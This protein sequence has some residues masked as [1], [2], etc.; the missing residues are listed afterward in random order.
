MTLVYFSLFSILYAIRLLLD[1]PVVRSLSGVSD[2][3]RQHIDLWITVILLI[4]FLLFLRQ[5]LGPQIKTLVRVFLIAQ[6][7]A[8]LAITADAFGVAGKLRYS[9]NNYLVL[10]I[11]GGLMANFLVLR[12]RGLGQPWTLELRVLITGLLVF[13]AFVLHGNLRSLGVLRGPDVE[14]F[15]FLFFVG[16][17]GYV[18]AH[19]AFAT[20]Q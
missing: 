13:G 10:A 17:L 18:A 8:A 20:R 14:A 3:V 7:F 1:M 6:I 5:V 12:F 4:P 15:G 19:H 16:C 2:S 9:L 11:V